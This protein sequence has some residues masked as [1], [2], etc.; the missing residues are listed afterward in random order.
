MH[1]M[2]NTIRLEE[3][4]MM[5]LSFYALYFFHAGWWWYLLLLLGP[6]ISMAGYLAG[7]RTG[8]LTYN[9]FHHK[10]IA[11]L[12]FIGGLSLEVTALS[13][14]GIVLLGHSSLDRFLGYG[15]KFSQG[16]KYTHLGT[17]GKQQSE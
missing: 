3:L 1:K 9:L 6:D 13:L 17:I 2:K 15:L 14:S 11:I 8:A 12:V 4:A 16:F 10:A 5:A 7:N